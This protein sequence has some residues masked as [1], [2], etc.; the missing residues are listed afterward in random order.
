MSKLYTAKDF[1]KT[2]KVI[3]FSPEDVLSRALFALSSSHDACFVLDDKGILLGA[4]NPYYAQFHGSF[5]PETKLKRCM[6]MPPKLSPQTKLPQILHNMLE[7]KIYFL[8]V[9]DERDKLLG[10]VS[11]R[12]IL[13]F[14]LQEDRV[15]QFLKEHLKPRKPQ[16]VTKDITVAKAR[17]LLKNSQHS[18]LPVV[19]EAGT[20][21]G[22]LTRFDLRG[23]L[24][25]PA[26]PNRSSRVGQKKTALKQPISDYMQ[27][28][29][30]TA[31][32]K[33]SIDEVFNILR[34]N[35]VGSVVLVDSHNKPTGVIAYRDILE[36]ILHFFLETRFSFLL[37]TPKDFRYRDELKT[38]VVSKLLTLQNSMGFTKVDGRL[39][40]GKG[41]DQSDKWFELSLRLSTPRQDFSAK[42][43]GVGWRKATALTLEKIQ[44]QFD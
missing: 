24:S 31:P 12:R 33:S 42:Q 23:I 36:N 11:F 29:I 13:K 17:S 5:P 39:T 41:M 43:R 3:S 32:E 21:I 6:S 28:L 37:D 16:L 10:I 4:V 1:L 9:V 22:L 30:V 35:K 27:K 26:Q 2:E 8:P 7:S 40:I 25:E 38:L 18:R 14:L 20:L 19:N 15:L 44:A 34:A